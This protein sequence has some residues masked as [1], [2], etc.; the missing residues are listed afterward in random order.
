MRPMRC[1]PVGPE[2][3]PSASARP[4]LDPSPMYG[5]TIGAVYASN[6]PLD[7]AYQFFDYAKVKS[8]TGDYNN[9]YLTSSCMCR[10]EY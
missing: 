8:S 6:S 4:L 9:E 1:K 5:S 10:T 2:S 3:G 7:P